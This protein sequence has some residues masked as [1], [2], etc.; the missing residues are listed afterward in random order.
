M[1]ES[2]KNGRKRSGGRRR[3]RRTVIGLA[4]VFF[5]ALLTVIVI[6][7]LLRYTI[8]RYDP[9]VIISGVY[10]GETDVSG[11]TREQ[12]KEAAET[13]DN[14]KIF[15]VEY[16]VTEEGARQTLE[17]RLNSLLKA[18]VNA[19]LTQSGEKTVVL[20]DTPGE[21][22]DITATVANINQ[23]IGG[24]WDKR[25]GAVQAETAVREADI[26]VEQLSEITDVLGTFSTWYGD[27]SDGRK[28]N[29]ESGARHLDGMLVKPGEEVSV[30]D[31]TAPYT[32]EN[33]YAMAPS[34]ENGEVV[35][36]MGGG[37]CQVSTTL[38]NTL[39]LSEVEIVERYAHSREVSY[40]D[41]SMDAAIAGD[42]KEWRGSE[43]GN[44]QLQSVQRI[45][46]DD[47]GGNRFG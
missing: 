18:P 45:R 28:A 3:N 17:A 19:R 47:R 34:Y 10:V 36:S 16:Q 39:L 41:P 15:P 14:Q 7:I 29:V 23:L 20:E 43:P 21:K 8:S 37:I 27:S 33:G 24:E 42:I 9:D 13:N 46:R 4:A 35:D 30:H 31:V 11:M 38:Y 25:G 26:T 22:L 6:Q 5:C 1:A 32:E 40:V 2:R 44:S 12:A